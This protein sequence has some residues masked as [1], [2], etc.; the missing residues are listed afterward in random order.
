M[1]IIKIFILLFIVVSLASCQINRQIFDRSQEES[2][3]F[4]RDLKFEDHRAEKVYVVFNLYN[5]LNETA[6]CSVKISLYGD[7]KL[8][9]EKKY[10]IGNIKA[11]SA[12]KIRIL[13]DMPEGETTVNVE[14]LCKITQ[15][16]SQIETQNQGKAEFNIEKFVF[17]E[18]LELRTSDFGKGVLVFNLNNTLNETINCSAKAII[19][20]DNKTILEK[21]KYIGNIEGSSIKNDEIPVN[22]PQGKSI[23]DVIPLCTIK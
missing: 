1:K 8:I 5:I 2:N 22:V 12:K 19:I 15:V 23:L 17:I 20:E 11:V 16:K 9:S 21:I 3:F 4:I 14:P 10:Y 7:N 6:N 18:D 13:I